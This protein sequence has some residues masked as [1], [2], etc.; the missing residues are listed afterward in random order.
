M[1]KRQLKRKPIP[2]TPRAR[3]KISRVLREFKAGTLR[4]SSGS[5]VRT[6]KQAQA[7]AFSTARRRK[8]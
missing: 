2:R 1:G 4:S 6:R 8:R 5:R 7:I 3:R